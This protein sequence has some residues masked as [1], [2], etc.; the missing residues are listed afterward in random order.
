M[1]TL[2][3]P[4]RYLQITDFDSS[5]NITNKEL[6]S[7]GKDSV[8]MIQAIFCGHCSVAKPAYQEFAKQH[9]KK[10]NVLT[11]CPDGGVEGEKELNSLLPTIAPGFRGFPTYVK[12]DKKGKY[13]GTL[14][15]TEGRSKE[16][17]EKFTGM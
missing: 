10:I 16:A 17:I 9:N 8:I 2:D 14:P 15:M 7:S 6:L 13:A 5:G 12:Y 3:F 11:I 1:Q 4:V